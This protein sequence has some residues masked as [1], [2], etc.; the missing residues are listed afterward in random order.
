[1]FAG[2]DRYG[3]INRR[4][5]LSVLFLLPSACGAEQGGALAQPSNE[6]DGADQATEEAEAWLA[7][8]VDSAVLLRWTE[9]DDNRLSG[10]L[11][12]ARMQS[13]DVSGESWPVEGLLGDQDL[14]LTIEGLFGSVTRL[15]GDFSGAILTLYWPSESGGLEAM[16]FQ[17]STIAE[18][19]EVVARLQ[20]DGANQ[21]AW[22]EQAEMESQAIADADEELAR[23][24]ARLEQTLQDYEASKDWAEASIGLV[25]TALDS[26]VNAVESLEDAVAND[27]DYA[28]TELSWVE[29]EFQ[30]LEGEVAYARGDNGIGAIG[31]TLADFRVAIDDVESAIQAVRHVEGLYLNSEF[32]P[33]N[34]TSEESLLADAQ[35]IL[36]SIGPSVETD[37]RLQID[38]LLEEAE[39]LV[40][41]ARSLLD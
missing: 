19:N 3:R 41:Y 26:L 22:A 15:T 31:N 38:E 32:G 7:T 27:P 37:Y 1:M 33:Y 34:A 5:L 39:G 25:A 40:E 28:P 29:S 4:L 24:K 13:Y 36:D 23:A 17:R 14:T 35:F 9:G 10:V 6:S 20:S 12:I 21:R 18:Y 16:Q 8:D 30:Y 2:I 11:Q